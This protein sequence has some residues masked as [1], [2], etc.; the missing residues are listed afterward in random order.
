[1]NS[2]VR[3]TLLAVSAA[4]NLWGL[5]EIG[6]YAGGWHHHQKAL[7]SAEKYRT[8]VLEDRLEDAQQAA[9]QALQ[10]IG[11]ADQ[12]YGVA[13]RYGPLSQVIQQF[14]ETFQINFCPPS[15]KQ[16]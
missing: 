14:P 11:Q 5:A 10:Q 15:A 4:F 6:A 7:A 1:M 13:R 12:W 2:K 3:N 16:E 9:G 8:A